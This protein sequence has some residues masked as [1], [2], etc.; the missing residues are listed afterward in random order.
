ME[1]TKYTPKMNKKGFL[2]RDF[3]V[4]GIIFG[5]VIALFVILVASTA[6]Q[7]NNT[8]IV[9]PNFAKHYST[10]NTNLQQLDTSN[11]AVQGAGGLNLI[12]T[13]N[14]AFNSVFTVIAMVWDGIS[15]YTGMA[16]NVAGDFNFLD[17]TTVLMFLGGII[18]ILTV[19]LIFIWISSVSRGKL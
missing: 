13:F 17:Q 9:S 4:V 10:L 7:Y 5:M 15:I 16:G 14:V 19:Y 2:A 1:Q 11:K 3:V 18:A 12:G 6:N 8:D